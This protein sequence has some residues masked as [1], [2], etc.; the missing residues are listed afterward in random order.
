MALGFGFLPRSVLVI[1]L[2]KD[3]NLLWKGAL[4]AFLGALVL[5]AG[6]AAIDREVH[7]F[8]H[9]G[10]DCGEA[11][12]CIIAIF[13]AGSVGI[14]SATVAVALPRLAVDAF[15]LAGEPLFAPLS[16]LRGPTAR[17]PPVRFSFGR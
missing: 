13:D 3:R 6:L 4:A 2:L 12:I 8:L 16:G 11:A 1:S 14:S 5:V 17:A 10:E 7:A 15:I 9:G